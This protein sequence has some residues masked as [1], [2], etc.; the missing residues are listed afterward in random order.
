MD[1]DRDT[2]AAADMFRLVNSDLL[3]RAIHVLAMLGI[4]DLLVSGPRTA[5]ELADAVGVH[6]PSL[7]RLLRATACVGVFAER[8]DGAFELTTRAQYLRSDTPGTARYLAMLQGE[9]GKASD[10]QHFLHAVRTGEPAFPHAYD[11]MDYFTFLEANPAAGGVFDKA[12]TAMSAGQS[13]TIAAAYDFGRFDVVA[14]IGGGSGHL[15]A[16]IL[17][18]HPEVRGV[19]FDRPATV[20]DAANL[21]DQHGVAERA[22]VI[23]GDFFY[24]VPPGAQAYVLKSVLHDWNDEDCVRILRSVHAAMRSRPDSR[25]MLWEFIVPPLNA[26]DPSKL[27]DLQMMLKTGGRERTEDEWRSLLR[28]AGFGDIVTSQLAAPLWLIEATPLTS[29]LPDATSA[30]TVAGD[31][32]G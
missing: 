31:A 17:E 14:D 20:A 13:T 27:L 10:H 8:P 25:L 6:G 22:N 9:V 16:T 23:S 2:Q 29:G 4:A 12:M 24:A 3:A 11:G 7:R 19:L 30:S 1:I 15:L 26:P 21:L 28:S 5:D 18:R 32:R